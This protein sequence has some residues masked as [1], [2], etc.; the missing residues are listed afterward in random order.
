MKELFVAIFLGGILGLAITS[1]LVALN[2][3]Y[4]NNNSIVNVTPPKTTASSTTITPKEESKTTIS[5]TQNFIDIK[6][7]KAN[8]VFSE[9]PILLKGSTNSNSIVIINTPLKTYTLNSDSAG[10]FS[11]NIEIDSGINFIDITSIDSQNSEAQQ[12]IM[13]TYSTAKI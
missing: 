1:G 4:K 11:E 8:S 5:E 3:R 9:S 13:V 12:E 10:N 6:T 7:P 2:N